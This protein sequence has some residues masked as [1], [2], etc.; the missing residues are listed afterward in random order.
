M[1]TSRPK[2][3]EPAGLWHR[4]A[5]LFLG[6]LWILVVAAALSA[7]GFSGM[8]LRTSYQR[9]AEGSG[10][11]VEWQKRKASVDALQ[12]VQVTYRK[13]DHELQE[14]ERGLKSALEVLKNGDKAGVAN[15][16][17]SRP[18]ETPMNAPQPE[19]GRLGIDAS[20]PSTAAENG[21]RQ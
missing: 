18:V 17:A 21:G 11:K 3:D 8:T 13:V 5:G 20:S 2:P 15:P 1:R 19:S 4:V 14:T 10:P 6:L 16:A 12:D 9:A 7:I